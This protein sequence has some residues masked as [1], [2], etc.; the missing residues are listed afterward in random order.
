[1]NLYLN[2]IRLI[3]TVALAIV[4]YLISLKVKEAKKRVGFSHNQPTQ[5]FLYKIQ[6]LTK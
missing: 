3:L 5:A 1:M 6:F 2:E 4:S